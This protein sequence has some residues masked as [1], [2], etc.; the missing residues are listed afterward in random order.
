VLPDQH[1]QWTGRVSSP[2]DLLLVIAWL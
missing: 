2:D 1:S